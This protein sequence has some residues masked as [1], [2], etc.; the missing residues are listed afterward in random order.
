MALIEE[1]VNTVGL[2]FFFTNPVLFHYFILQQYSYSN[3][4][5]LY[6][7]VWLYLCLDI[8]HNQ[9]GKLHLRQLKIP[10]IM[11]TLIS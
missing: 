1:L 5:F 7:S 9:F 4:L 6:Y 10:Y 3:R 11:Y 2:K 8:S